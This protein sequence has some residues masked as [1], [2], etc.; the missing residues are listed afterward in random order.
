[1]KNLLLG[2]RGLIQR[3]HMMA[4]QPQVVRPGGEKEDNLFIGYHLPLTKVC[5][6]GITSLAL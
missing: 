4:L 6:L 3:S 2:V 5:C 1:M